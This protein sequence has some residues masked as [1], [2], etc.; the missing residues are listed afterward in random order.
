M[1]A[2]SSR[3]QRR[4]PPVDGKIIQANTAAHAAAATQAAAVPVSRI[5]GSP[6]A[7]PIRMLAV[8]YMPA[9]NT[10]IH[11][12]PRNPVGARPRHHRTTPSTVSGG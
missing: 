2:V 12:S 10:I 11:S 9:G 7:D 5:S 1:R 8:A 3:S 4:D 6:A